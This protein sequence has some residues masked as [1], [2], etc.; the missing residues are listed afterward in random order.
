MGDGLTA[1]VNR[2]NKGLTVAVTAVLLLAKVDTP[3]R[4]FSARVSS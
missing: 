1:S 4:I 2:A 3:S